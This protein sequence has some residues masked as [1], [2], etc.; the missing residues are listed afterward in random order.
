MLI[1]TALPLYHIF[2]LTALFPVRRAATAASACSSPIRATSPGL[3]KELR[4]YKVNSFP[5]VNTLY[6]ALLQSS[7]F[8]ARSTG[9]MLKCAIGGGMAVQ[10]SV[11]EAWMKATG[12]P[13]IEGYGLSETSPVLTCNRGDIAEW[14]G[15]IGLPL[16]STDISIRDD[17][18]NE[19]PPASQARFAR[20]ARR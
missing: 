1:V 15:T 16:P 8:Q 2:A 20:A 14:T 9:A 18:G 3:I 17:D 11:A 4:K 12:R 5:A 10:K 19:V 13:I 7:G 6:N